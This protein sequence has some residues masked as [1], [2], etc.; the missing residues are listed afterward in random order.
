[1]QHFKMQMEKI[2]EDETFFQLRWQL[3]NEVCAFTVDVYTDYE[4]LGELRKGVSEFAHF[5][6]NEFKIVFGKDSETSADYLSMRFFNLD[7]LGHI[8]IEIEADN[9][10]EIPDAAR[11]HLY[12]KAVLHD[13]DVIVDQLS[14]FIRE[15]TEEIRC[16]AFDTET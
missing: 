6:R 15:E 11:V 2:W 1:M 3:A 16:I 7:S 8:G 5:K 10:K 13:L 14:K 12:I 9:K 4:A